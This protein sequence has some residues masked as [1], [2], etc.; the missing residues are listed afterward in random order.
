MDGVKLDEYIRFQF[1]RKITGLYK[2]FLVILED[3]RESGIINANE[4]QKARKKVLDWGND[5]LRELDEHLD[6]VNFTLK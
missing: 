5:A 2:N 3:Q 6:K 1:N 4:Y